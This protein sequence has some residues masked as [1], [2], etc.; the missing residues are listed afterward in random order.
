MF[1]Q[2]WFTTR[3]LSASIL[4]TALLTSV[5]AL[6]AGARAAQAAAPAQSRGQHAEHA[7]AGVVK[8]IDHG[9]KVM[10]IGTADGVE[11]S[12]KFTERTT[13]RGAKGVAHAADVAAKDGLEG[14]AVVLYYTGEGIEKSAVRVD[15]LG[16]RT[17]HA[18]K[19]SVERVDAAGTV[20]VVKTASGA[21]ETFTL[22]KDVAID[23]GK[24][25]ERT[26]A[27]VGKMLKAGTEVTVHYSEA[28]GKKIAHVVKHV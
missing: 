4:A 19:G 24:G 14:G 15:H 12:V 8:K 10:V 3:H 28:G 13:V 7:V 2:H 25:V 6:P 5:L 9:A 16:K 20:V 17:I 1:P 21:E 27:D 11:E 22:G 26:G 18:A 23:A